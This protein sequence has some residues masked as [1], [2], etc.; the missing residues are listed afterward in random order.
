MTMPVFT[1]PFARVIMDIVGPIQPV[2]S[3]GYRY[4]FT[5]MD[6]STGFSEA[7]PLKNIDSISVAELYCKYS[8]V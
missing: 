4:I 2:S 3:E 6:F 8:H 1:E 7:I 5:L